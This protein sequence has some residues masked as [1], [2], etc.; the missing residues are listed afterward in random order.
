MMIPVCLMPKQSAIVCIN[1]SKRALSLDCCISVI[2]FQYFRSIFVIWISV[3][4]TE[5]EHG[6]TGGANHEAVAG[7][8]TQLVTGHCRRLINLTIL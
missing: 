6:T 4:H 7:C 3:T 8:L 1:Q 2:S 5:P